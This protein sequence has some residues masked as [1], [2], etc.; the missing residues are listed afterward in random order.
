V[1]RAG[2]VEEGFIR[3]RGMR[4]WYRIVGDLEQAAPDRLPLLLLHGGPGM[5]SDAFEPLEV[6]ADRGR[7]VVMYDQIGCGRSDRPTDRSLWRIESFVDEIGA[8]RRQLGLE[9]VHLLGWSWGG[10][11]AM[12][13]VLTKPDGVAS[14]VVSS[15]PAN[16]RLWIEEVRRLRDQLPEHVTR[17]M[18]RFEENYRPKERKRKRRVV[19]GTSTRR[20]QRI[21]VAARIVLSV[22][23][24][25]ICVRLASWASAVPFL[26]RVAYEVVN[27][28]FIKRHVMLG[29]PNKA[30]LCVFR[31]FAGTNR[32]VYETM[33]GPSEFFGTGVLKDWDITDRLGEI[34][35]PTLIT[36]G[37]MDEATPVQMQVLRDGIQGSRWVMFQNSAHAALLEEPERYRAVLEAFLENA[38]SAA[39]VDSGCGSAIE[40][41]RR[42][43]ADDFSVPSLSGRVTSLQYPR[44]EE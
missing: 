29:R 41:A 43:C 32:Q 12:Q 39:A 33:W 21:A 34:T 9:R 14:L 2:A 28:E 40:Q 6:L 22:A 31:S 10:M 8:V 24:S 16:T 13:Y 30:P 23:S 18:R 20:A 5:P 4:T 36:S 44:G 37:R 38:E 26:R 3:F 35:I 42:S 25:P 17:A 19:Q 11:L 7:P 27:T 1:R 15:A